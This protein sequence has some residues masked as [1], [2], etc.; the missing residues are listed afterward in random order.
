[1]GTGTIKRPADIEEVL[2]SIVSSEIGDMLQLDDLYNLMN[3]MHRVEELMMGGILKQ[4]ELELK[5][6]GNDIVL[7]ADGVMNV[8]SARY[9]RLIIQRVFI[10]GSDNSGEIYSH[11]NGNFQMIITIRKG[12]SRG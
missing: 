11:G 2:H 4:V 9:E 10:S 3:V 7:V 6:Q 5:R 1:M 8:Q 12:V